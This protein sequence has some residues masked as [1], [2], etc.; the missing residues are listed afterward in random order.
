MSE[1]NIYFVRFSYTDNTKQ[2]R[3]EAY[4]PE[5]EAKN[6]ET[7]VSKIARRLGFDAEVIA[8]TKL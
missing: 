8:V 7:E 4:Y 6:F 3:T 2:K 1:K 5:C